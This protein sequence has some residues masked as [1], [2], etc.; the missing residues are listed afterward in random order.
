MSKL[1]VLLLLA[2]LSSGAYAGTRVTVEQVEQLL[3]ASHDLP[4]ARLA[5]KISD[6]ELTERAS[7]LRLSRWEKDF[8][9]KHTREALLALADASAFLDLP[10]AEVP[11]LEKPDSETRKQI[12]LRAIEYSR[13]TIHRLPD[14]SA[15]RN[16]THF[17]DVSPTQE[18]LNEYLVDRRNGRKDTVIP[19]S[20][21]ATNG[22]PRMRVGERSSIV[23]TY[24]DGREVVDG[25]AGKNGK[26]EPH[27]AG[28]TTFGEFGPI[29]SVVIADITH[30]KLNWGYWERGATG[31]LA[32]FRYE[33]PQEISH[34]T[35]LF[36]AGE[37]PQTPAYHGEI[38]VD[39]ANGTIRRVALVSQLI[40]PE[41]VETSILVE[42]S[43]LAIGNG[44]YICPVKGV[45]LSR[46]PGSTV[47]LTSPDDEGRPASY[48]TIPPQTLVN[49]VSFTEYHVFHG[50]VRIVP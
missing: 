4:D 30:G 37:K 3:T 49:D 23:V 16:T 12:F 8:P 9:G 25:E 15:R 47:Q 35:V 42:Y 48:A 45:A 1:A 40:A 5:A 28:L 6:L 32:V 14:F 26:S 38:A 39:P 41:A 34:Y 17:D 24:R 27:G 50:D 19:P 18:L 7:P 43:S 21:L 33:V 2:G 22:S 36:R 10:H 31:L 20:A 46:V 29:L 44:T 13:T 11:D